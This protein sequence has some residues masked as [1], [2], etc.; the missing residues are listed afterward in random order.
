MKG[1][2]MEKAPVFVKIEEYKD[3][4]DVLSVVKDKVSKARQLLAKIAELKQQ[5]DASLDEWSKDLDEVGQL[6]STIDTSLLSPE[7]P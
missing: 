4:L 7:E 5:E 3:V 1:E 2:Q 6:V